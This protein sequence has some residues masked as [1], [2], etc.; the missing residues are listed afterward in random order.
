[1]FLNDVGIMRM[2]DSGDAEHVNAVLS[3]AGIYILTNRLPEF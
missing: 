3:G 1:M 2:F